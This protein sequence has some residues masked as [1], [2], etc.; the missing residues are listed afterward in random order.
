MLLLLQGHFH[1]INDKTRKEY[2]T[3][4]QNTFEICSHL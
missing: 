1:E 3:H 4:L 2:Y